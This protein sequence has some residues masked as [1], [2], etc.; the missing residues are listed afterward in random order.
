MFLC[1]AC[2]LEFERTHYPDIFAREKL[3][4]KIS[5]P[6]S[7]IQVWFSNR[8][9]KWRREEK[10]RSQ[11]FDGITSSG[12]SSASTASLYSEVIIGGGGGS[13][14]RSPKRRDEVKT[15]GNGNY[16]HT[17]LLLRPPPASPNPSH[18]S[19]DLSPTSCKSVAAVSAAE[20]SIVVPGVT[21]V[22]T[23]APAYTNTNNDNLIGLFQKFHDTFN[24]ARAT[25]PAP[26]TP[27][28][29][30]VYSQPRLNS[31]YVPN[32]YS[33]SSSHVLNCPTSSS[34]SPPC[35]STHTST[36][37]VYYPNHTYANYFPFATLPSSNTYYEDVGNMSTTTTTTS[38]DNHHHHHNIT[39]F[40]GHELFPS[41]NVAYNNAPAPP[42]PSSSSSTTSSYLYY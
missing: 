38:F 3:S 20:L 30:A 13:M 17:S 41:A 21:E 15:V 28:A 33:S 10:L 29:T 19:A 1:D 27:A 40:P 6:E 39:S 36:S 42:A 8:R 2:N 14:K 7:R 22:S 34:S 9:A 23:F 32:D 37:S 26:V 16:N 11:K 31:A 35:P 4:A 25:P 18:N 24:P 12:N 5:L